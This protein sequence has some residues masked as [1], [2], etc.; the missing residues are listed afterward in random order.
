MDCDHE[1]A[2]HF[3]EMFCAAFCCGGSKEV[4]RRVTYSF[5][6][7]S[8]TSEGASMAS[9]IKS[10]E[11]PGTA[12]ITVSFFDSKGKPAKVDGVPTWTASNPA[13]IDVLTPSADGLSATLHILDNVDV[14]QL[15]AN[16]DVDMGSGVNNVDFVDTISVIAGDA[17]SATFALGPITPDP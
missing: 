17:S 4:T 1:V 9:V 10:T 7:I 14:S 3:R 5:K 16:A 12:T 2:R 11:V 6:G 8:F 13:V 15:T